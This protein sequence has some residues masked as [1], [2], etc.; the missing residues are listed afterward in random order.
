MGVESALCPTSSRALPQE[1][2][3]D[4]LAEVIQRSAKTDEKALLVDCRTSADPNPVFPNALRVRLT[5]IILR[6]V[7]NNKVPLAKFYPQ[8]ADLRAFHSLVFLTDDH[9][10]RELAATIVRT[11][12][13][14]GLQ[15]ANFQGN[16]AEFAEFAAR[17]PELLLGKDQENEVP[18]PSNGLNFDLHEDEDTFDYKSRHA[19]EFPALILKDVYL[20]NYETAKNYEILKSRGISYVINVTPNLPNVFEAYPH[21][22]YLRIP[23]DDSCHAYT[24][25]DYFP[26]AI[27]FIK[28][29]RADN[30]A[31]LVHCLAGISRSVTVCLAYL[32]FEQRS[33]LDRAFDLLHK[34][35]AS[36][37]PNFHFMTALKRWEAEILKTPHDQYEA[38]SGNGT[39]ASTA[40]SACSSA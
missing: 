29:A 2:N 39:A 38:D 17:Y 16:A 20:G 30:A 36:I 35:N 4:E 7:Q 3:A 1:L 34:Q 33:T 10:A 21:M 14:G 25:P 5:A 26:A 22:N 28:K 31:V 27:A 18:A 15:L 32:I 13:E 12:D 23:V 19:V 9:E 11:L 8:F 40:S 37:A 6:R 24:L